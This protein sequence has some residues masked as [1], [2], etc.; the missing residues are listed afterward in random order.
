MQCHLAK[1]IFFVICFLFPP[2]IKLSIFRTLLGDSNT[3]NSLRITMDLFSRSW[4]NFFGFFWVCFLFQKNKILKLN[5][6]LI[7][8]LCI[9]WFASYTPRTGFIFILFWMFTSILSQDSVNSAAST[10]FRDVISAIRK[11]QNLAELL[12]TEN[13][14]HLSQEQWPSQLWVLCTAQLCTSP[15]LQLLHKISSSFVIIKAYNVFH[16]QPG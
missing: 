13:K 10:Y 11:V 5:A 6:L 3:P 9:T 8:H 7:L 12:C 4:T 16:T 14:Q 15:T 1:E 2:V